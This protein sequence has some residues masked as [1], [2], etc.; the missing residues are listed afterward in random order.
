MTAIPYQQWP[1][2]RSFDPVFFL[3]TRRC[4][5]PF[6]DRQHLAVMEREF[7]PDAPDPLELPLYLKDG[8]Q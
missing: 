6:H 7:N 8:G 2:G 3:D 4:L 5:D 1:T